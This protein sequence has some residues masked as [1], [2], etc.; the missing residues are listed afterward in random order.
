M[1]IPQ[2]Q[3]FVFTKEDWH[4]SYKLAGWFRGQQNLAL[5]H[6]KFHGKLNTLNGETIFRTAVWG[7]DDF[8]MEYDSDDEQKVFDLFVKITQMG[9]VTR[10]ALEKLGFQ[11][12]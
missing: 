10:K 2:A 4:G 1:S 8:G 7:S 9:N 6:V 12:A 5:L 11:H 3:A